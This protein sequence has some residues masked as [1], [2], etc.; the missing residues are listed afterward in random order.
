MPLTESRRIDFKA[1]V[2]LVKEHERPM[3]LR[4]VQDQLEAEDGLGYNSV[5]EICEDVR[6][7]F[8]NAMACNLPE[9][10]IYKYAKYLLEKFEEK[11]RNVLEPKLIEV[12]VLREETLETFK[13]CSWQMKC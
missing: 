8:R 1:S 9:I 2:D 11:W 7:V 4:N 6:L 13:Q 3:D 5:H 10:D 12:D